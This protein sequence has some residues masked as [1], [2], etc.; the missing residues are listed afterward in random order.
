MGGVGGICVVLLVGCLGRDE[1]ICDSFM[2]DA[3]DLFVLE[4]IF[5]SLDAFVEDFFSLFD[6]FF[7]GSCN[8]LGWGGVFIGNGYESWVN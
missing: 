7:N 2:L 5:N 1:L 3:F 4:L 8:G 6:L